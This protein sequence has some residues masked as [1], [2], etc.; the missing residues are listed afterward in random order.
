MKDIKQYRVYF[1]GFIDLFALSENDVKGYIKDARYFLEDADYY[2]IT[3]IDKIE[4]AD[5]IIKKE[6]RTNN[7]KP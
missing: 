1:E 5:R 2:K 4:G 6:E 7:V 3:R